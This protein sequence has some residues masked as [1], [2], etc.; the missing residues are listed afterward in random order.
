MNPQRSFYS[1]SVDSLATHLLLLF[2]FKGIIVFQIYAVHFIMIAHY[3]HVMA[4]I[5][6]SCRQGLNI[7]FLI[8]QQK[9]KKTLPIKLTKTTQLFIW[10][11]IKSKFIHI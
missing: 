5:D 11:E 9:N 3:H 10:I 8:Q 1:K 4:P 2:V 7:K 6:F